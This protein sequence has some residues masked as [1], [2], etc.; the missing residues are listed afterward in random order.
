MVKIRLKDRVEFSREKMAKVLLASTERLQLDLYCLEAGQSQK[1]H[2]HHDTD[3]VYY[4]VEGEGRITLGGASEPIEAGEAAVA[5]A[6]I[7]H[8]LTNTGQSRMV[9]LVIVAPPPTH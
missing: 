6:G 7:E 9:C 4:V 5:N 3:K 2:A 1:P 8:G